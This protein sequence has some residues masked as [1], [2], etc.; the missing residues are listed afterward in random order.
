MCILFFLPPLILDV[1][2]YSCQ[3]NPNVLLYHVGPL[4]SYCFLLDMSIN[5]SEVLVSPDVTVFLSVAPFMS[6]SICIIYLGAPIL[7][8]Y[9]LMSV[10]SSSCY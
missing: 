10:I 7:G 4:S 5:V 3:L 6:V 2:S 9:M 1:V 8:A